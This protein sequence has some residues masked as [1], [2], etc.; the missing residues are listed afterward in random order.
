MQIW[1]P[2]AEVF[3]AG[4]KDANGAIAAQRVVVGTNGVALADVGRNDWRPGVGGGLR[5]EKRSISWRR[6]PAPT[7]PTMRP[8]LPPRKRRRSRCMHDVTREPFLSRHSVVVRLTHWLNVLC[9]TF[10]LLSGLQI[11][12]AYPRLHWGQYGADADPAF[13]E[14]GSGDSNGQLY[15]SVTIDGR[16]FVTTGVLGLSTSGRYGDTAGI[17]GMA[18]DPVVPGPCFRPAV[19]F[20]L[21]LGLRH[22]GLRSIWSYGFRSGHF[23]RDLEPN[24]RE[25]APR[26]FWRE[27]VDHA[28]CAS[29]PA[30]TGRRYNVL[31]KLTYIA[32]IAILLPLMV[33]TGLTMSPGMDAAFPVLLDIFGGRQVRPHDSLH[34]RIAARPVRHR[35]RRH[36]ASSRV[37]EQHAFDDHGSLRH[38]A[39]RSRSM[40]ALPHAVAS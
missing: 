20:L 16:S 7:I 17:P 19:A 28:A 5:P 4:E 35:S 26:Q 14:I 31:Q 21:C 18:H 33:L 29:I 13:I 39:R 30:S 6:H 38:P 1:K 2:G 9:L 32:V 23:R 10:L 8:G 22:Q 11:F 27:I 12:N 15:G 34:H 25:L 37:L 40:T 3:I 24:R 36:G